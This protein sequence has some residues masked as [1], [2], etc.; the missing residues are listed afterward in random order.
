MYKFEPTGRDC[1]KLH[2][3]F[4]DNGLELYDLNADIGERNNLA[5]SHPEKLK[6]LQGLLKQKQ[7]EMNAPIPFD[8]NPDYQN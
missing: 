8:L 1:R 2:H 4:E 7:E 3:Y 5:E 6:E